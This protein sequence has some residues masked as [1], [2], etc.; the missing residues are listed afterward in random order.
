MLFY[1]LMWILMNRFR[2][3]IGSRPLTPRTVDF[4]IINTFFFNFMD[5]IKL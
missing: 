1:D 3:M 5:T 2:A 4:Y